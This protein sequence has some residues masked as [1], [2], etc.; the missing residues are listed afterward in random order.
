MPS[1]RGVMDTRKLIGSR[2]K[3]LRRA[4]GYSQERLGEIIGINPKYLSSV[5]RGRENPTLD[6]FIRLSQGLK[7][8]IHEIFLI[9]QEGLE[10]K[11]LRKKLRTLVAEV[12]DEELGRVIRALGAFIH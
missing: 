5:E 8:G 9:E 12:K 7:V 1:K 2:I 10:P 3:N 4:R 6:L 11:F